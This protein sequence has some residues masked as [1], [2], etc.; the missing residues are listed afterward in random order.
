MPAPTVIYYHQVLRAPRPEHFYFRSAPTL[1]Q[2]KADMELVRER[3]HPLALD[4]F[5]AGWASRRWPANAVMVT[6]DDG[7]RNNLL[8]AEI[9]HELGMSAV[10]F[11]LSDVVDSDF[12]P[13][14]LRYGHVLATRKGDVFDLPEGRVDFNNYLGFRKWYLS[15][16]ERLLNLPPTERAAALD[17]LGAALGSSPID[18]NDEDYQYFSTADLK[19]LRELGQSVGSHAATHDKLSRCNDDELR[20]EVLESHD[21]LTQLLGEPVD[22][23][24]YPDGRFTARTVELAQQRYKFGFASVET[25][26]DT[27]PFR[28]PRRDVGGAGAGRILSRWYAPKRRMI[29]TF[30]RLLGE[31]LPKFEEA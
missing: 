15:T 12:K 16:K 20:Y 3:Y 26:P 17:A 2:F 18:P 6:F 8:A 5:L 7:F 28:Y 4:E 23:I 29:R 19:R 31:P 14:Y 1:A 11:V 27:D 21:K 22:T 10:F 13:T 9:L 25:F 24:S 30:K